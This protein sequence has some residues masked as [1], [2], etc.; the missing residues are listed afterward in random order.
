MGRVGRAG[1]IFEWWIGD[2]APR[3]IHVSDRNGNLLGRI[4]L[5][6]M[7]ALDDW[8]PPKKVIEIIRRLLEENRL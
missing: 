4:A 6:S 1:Y 7:E 8:K 2:H 3:H 5:G